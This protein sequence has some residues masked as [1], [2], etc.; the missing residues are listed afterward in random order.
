[1]NRKLLVHAGC[2]SVR[3]DGW[4]HVDRQYFPGIDFLADLGRGLPVAEA[5]AVFAE[6]FLEHLEPL[7][8]LAFLASCGEVLRP[9]AGWLRL[10]TPNLDWVLAEH[11]RATEN[12]RDRAAMA[13]TLNRAF[14]GWGHRFL[15]NEPA[16]RLA[17]EACGFD[18]IRRERFG[19]SRL[20]FFQGVERHETYPDLDG[21]PH[22]LVL[23]ARAGAPDPGRFREASDYL[24]REFAR[25]LEPV[26]ERALAR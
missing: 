16:L 10:S 1:M 22:V 17:L 5:D 4:I 26:V 15:W 18:E 24:A 7:D 9:R 20:S 21:L 11:Y 14:R 12:P 13:V 6:H 19:E 8:A 23:E 2:G 3:L 25:H